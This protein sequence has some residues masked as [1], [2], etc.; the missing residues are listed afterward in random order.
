MNSA[1]RSAL[2]SCQGSLEAFAHWPKKSKR[3]PSP[4]ALIR[5]SSPEPPGGAMTKGRH[6]CSR[7]GIQRASSLTIEK[8][9]PRKARSR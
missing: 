8:R 9:V 3:Q 4:W 6:S 1:F 7:S 5:M 2:A